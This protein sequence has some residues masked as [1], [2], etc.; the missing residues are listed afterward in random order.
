VT[1]F[2][3]HYHI[4]QTVVVGL[5]A[6]LSYDIADTI[7]FSGI[8]SILFCGMVMTRY[9]EEN[10][11]E[12]SRVTL[13]YLMKMTAGTAEAL[14]SLSVESGNRFYS[15][16]ICQ[17]FIYIGAI[18]VTQFVYNAFERPTAIWDGALIIVTIAVIIPTR[19]V[20][21]FFLS[22]LANKRRMRP[23]SLR[24]Q[25]YID[26]ICY[27]N[28]FDLL[29]SSISPKPKQIILG[30]QQRAL[31]YQHFKSPPHPPSMTSTQVSV[32]CADRLRLRWL[33]CCRWT[34]PVAMRSSRRRSSSFGSRYVFLRF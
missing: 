30:S 6:L 18:S 16:L 10:F 2:T 7:G 12:D 23:I 25:V 28:S 21:T 22:W 20:V 9:A 24:N 29:T 3:A 32:D 26:V 19:F 27:Q 11:D 31:V 33:S 8:T 17:V 34:L 5:C 1:K 4:I 14:V 13:D 15:P